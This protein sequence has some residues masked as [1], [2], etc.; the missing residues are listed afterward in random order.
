MQINIL[1]L[2]LFTEREKVKFS[3]VLH[4]KIIYESLPEDLILYGCLLSV[5]F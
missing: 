2:Y 3:N 1:L 4:V 5:D